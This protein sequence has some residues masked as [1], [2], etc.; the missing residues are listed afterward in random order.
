M[1]K[2]Q[3]KGFTLI[4]LLIVIAIIAIL[5]AVVILTLNPAELLKQARDSTRVTDLATLNH[6][7]SLY[8]ADVASPQLAPSGNY[9]YC[10]ESLDMDQAAC[11]FSASWSYTEIASTSNPV[12]TVDGFGWLPVNFMAIGSGAPIGNLPIDPV[13]S[14][15]SVYRYVASSSLV[16]ELNGKMESVKFGNDTTGLEATDGG[17]N[18]S[19]YEVENNAGL[20]L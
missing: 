8:L 10:Y 2:T 18:T 15:T 13:N 7:L 5:A 17:N 19:L 11:G 9:S 6:A 3:Q 14:S 4:E 1:H 16:Y 12:R 20:N